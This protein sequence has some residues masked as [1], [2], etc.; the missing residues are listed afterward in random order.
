MSPENK[1]EM[2]ILVG[3][4]PLLYS[5]TKSRYVCILWHFIILAKVQQKWFVAVW[6]V[7]QVIV[8]QEAVYNCYKNILQE[9]FL[10]KGHLGA[11]GAYT[12]LCFR[13]CL[14]SN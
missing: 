13:V 11:L 2:L 3:E 1:Y 4:I 8:H 7:W 5:K 10:Q 14:D 6:D 9:Y 12:V